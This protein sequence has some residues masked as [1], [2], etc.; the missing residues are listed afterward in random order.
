[1]PGDLAISKQFIFYFE[2]LI[3][4]K[5]CWF[6]THCAQNIMV[7]SRDDKDIN[8]HPD[9]EEFMPGSHQGVNALVF[10]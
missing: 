9:L 8:A 2:S 3:S 10:Y 7:E 6:N 5:K 1:M 4:D